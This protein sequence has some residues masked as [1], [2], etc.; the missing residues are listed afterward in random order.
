MV[1]RNQFV[2]AQDTV[3]SVGDSWFRFRTT[4]ERILWADTSHMPGRD[5]ARVND[6]GTLA[7]E[8][9]P[10]HEVTALWLERQ[11]TQPSAAAIPSAASSGE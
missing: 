4:A 11:R 1:R 10:R 5:V 6:Q 8:L 2:S 7:Y 9:I 3:E